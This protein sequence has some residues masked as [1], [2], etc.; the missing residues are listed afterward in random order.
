LQESARACPA[1]ER[2]TSRLGLIGA[3]ALLALCLFAVGFWLSPLP[4]EDNAPALDL[5]RVKLPRPEP[6]TEFSLQEVEEHAA[7][8]PYTRA[9]LLGQWTL[10]YFGY[11][12][13]PDVCG[14]A[15]SVLAQVSTRLRAAP[16]AMAGTGVVFITL[17]PARDSP[18]ALRR[19]LGRVDVD[20]V[21][22]RGNEQQIAGLAQQ[23][24]ILHLPRP[25]DAQGGYLVDHPATILLI[26]PS[27]ELRAGFS[28][29]RDAMRIV[30]LMME[31][32]ADYRAAKKG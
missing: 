11:T 16:N 31:I 28:M 23:L 6:L 17:D 8:A 21:A 32:E 5:E 14:S 24:G 7:H 4:E 2:Y 29:P 13:C 20:I 26:D 22:L 10:L 12:N 18:A 19:F 15:L 3:Y 30:E 27:A 25:P 9:R 1:P